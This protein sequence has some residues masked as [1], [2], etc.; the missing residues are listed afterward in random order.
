[1]VGPLEK[2][3]AG[4]T[5]IL[6]ILD[7]VIRYPEA[8]PIRSA[9]AT[10]IIRELIKVIA[11]MGIPMEIVI[12]QGM[13]FISQL[14]KELC[15]LLKVKSLRTLI[16]H[17]QSKGLVKQFNKTLKNMLRKFVITES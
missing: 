5:Y 1:M 9:T 6:V 13:N 10:V 15:N 14:M 8:I 3:T 12:D 16:Y 2:C 11:R 17:T 4:H 7:Y